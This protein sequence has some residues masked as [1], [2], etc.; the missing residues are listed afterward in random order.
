MDYALN[1]PCKKIEVV[2]THG[3]DDAERAEETDGETR[4]EKLFYGL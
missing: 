4:L 2:Y 1:E 3:C